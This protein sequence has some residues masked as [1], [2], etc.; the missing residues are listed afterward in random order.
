MTRGR[1]TPLADYKIA[2]A[3]EAEAF[4]MLQHVKAL[5]DS[6]Y[7]LLDSMTDTL[8]ENLHEAIEDI[9]NGTCDR[10]AQAAIRLRAS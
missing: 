1:M 2:V 7:V 3:E 6:E 4:A 5:M 8:V 9:Y 10:L